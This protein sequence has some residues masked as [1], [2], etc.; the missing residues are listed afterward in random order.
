MSKSALCFLS[1]TLICS[2]VTFAD[3]MSMPFW[4][5]AAKAGIGIFGLLFVASLL[6]G[7]RIK[8][9]PVLR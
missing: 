3:A 2:A 7:R 1:L 6:V 9:D 5:M 8:F 4:E